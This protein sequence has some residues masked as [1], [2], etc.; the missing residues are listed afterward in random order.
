MGNARRTRSPQGHI[1][2]FALLLGS[3]MITAAAISPARGDVL[4]QSATNVLSGS[5]TNP[6]GVG[7]DS[8]FF[9]GANFHLSTSAHLSQI[10]GNFGDFV[11]PGN[12]QVFGAVVPVASLTSPPVPADLSSNVLATTLITLPAA[13][14]SADV[15]G[16]LSLDLTPGFYGIVFGS[17][18]FGATGSTLAITKWDAVAANTGGVQTY[19]LRQSDGAFFTQAPGARY[20]AI[21]TVP[22]P[23]SAIAVVGVAA[24]AALSRR[25]RRGRGARAKTRVWTAMTC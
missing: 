12:G 23:S 6:S 11:S 24:T 25:R 19:A 7:V 17:G 18:K 20:V 1:V 8:S 22:E 2:L 4:Y 15:F 13:G 10:G 3:S 5:M 16:N 21:G 9:S 14:Q